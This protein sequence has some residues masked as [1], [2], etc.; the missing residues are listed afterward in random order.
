MIAPQCAFIALDHE[1]S[2]G[3]PLKHIGNKSEPIHIEKNCWIAFRA[4]ILS[5]VTVGE[6]SIV[7]AGAVVTKDV[8]PFSVVGGVPAKVIKQRNE[9]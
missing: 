8:P 4:T 6:G 1:F 2:A 9:K 3:D 5:G 7:A